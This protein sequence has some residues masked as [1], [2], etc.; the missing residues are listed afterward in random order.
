MPANLSNLTSER[1]LHSGARALH[2]WAPLFEAANSDHRVAHRSAILCAGLGE[3]AVATFDA[4][5]GQGQ[6]RGEEVLVAAAGL[7]LLTKLDDQVI[8][9]LPFHQ[10]DPDPRQLRRRLCAYL[11]PTLWSI[12]EATPAYPGEPRCELAAALGARLV[13]LAEGER[14]R[15]NHLLDV[16]AQ[17]W[18][19]QVEAV[20]TF[21]RHPSELDLALVDTVTA[22][23]SGLWLKMNAMVGALPSEAAR[24][25]NLAEEEAFL[26]WGAWIQRADA[27][28]D[29]A[30]DVDEGLA[31]TSLG[32]RLWSRAPEHYDAL[33]DGGADE[34]SYA[35]LVDAEVDR[36][37]VPSGEALMALERSL[38]ALG[39]VGPT[40]AWITRMLLWRYASCPRSRR[41]PH[42]PL[43]AGIFSPDAEV[44]SFLR[45][46]GFAHAATR[47]EVS[48]CSA[49]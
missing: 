16:I 20:V 33:R 37:L 35:A 15:L 5:G 29:F 22:A 4:L 49:P 27:L 7:S 43:W 17:G 46:V 41:P 45:G 39:E 23:I 9:G 19:V 32:W 47:E 13:A 26:A 38:D 48:P 28:A 21:T 18:A 8:D 25:M 11:W 12:F 31:C 14:G 34:A 44:S 36:A 10:T 3:L 2:A 6:G 24:P 40:L 42:D 30:K 1:L